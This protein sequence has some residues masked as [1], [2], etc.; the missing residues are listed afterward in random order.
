MEEARTSADNHSWDEAIE[1]YSKVLEQDID[2]DEACRQLARL[3]AVRGKFKSVI[4]SNLRLMRVFINRQD[5][6]NAVQV[7]N[8]LLLLVPESIEVRQELIKMYRSLGDM[9]EVIAR[10][11]ELARLYAE[12]DESDKALEL[13]QS[14]LRDDPQNVEVGREVAEMYIQSGQVEQGASRYRQV[15]DLYEAQGEYDKAIDAIQRV[16][17]VNNNDSNSIFHLGELF[18]KLERWDEAERQFRNTLKFNFENTEVMF[19]LGDVCQRK[20]DLDQAALAY[21][22]I[23]AMTPDFV[24]AQE[25]LGEVYQ[26]QGNGEQ[27]IKSYLSAANL[28]L[29]AHQP[30]KAISLYQRV[31]YFDNNNPTATRELT[32]LGAPVT[33]DDGGLQPVAKGKGGKGKKGKKGKGAEGGA[34][35]GLISKGGSARAGLMTKGGA[36]PGL[37]GKPVLGGDE[38]GPGSPRPGL[39]KAGLKSLGGGKMS[40]G[41]KPALG[42]KKTLSRKKKKEVEEAAAPPVEEVVEE[43]LPEVEA[44][45][46]SLHKEEEEAPLAEASAEPAEPIVEEVLPEA[47]G[48]EPELEVEPQ[49]YTPEVVPEP[50]S[51]EVEL[52]PVEDEGEYLGAEAHFNEPEGYLEEGAPYRADEAEGAAS[53]EQPYEEVEPLPGEVTEYVPA[54]EETLYGGYDFQS[55]EG[56]YAS[57][58]LPP[59]PQPYEEE[60]TGGYEEAQNW[61]DE[62]NPEL[63]NTV[64]VSQP[65]GEFS[66]QPSSAPSDYSEEY[67]QYGEEAKFPVEEIYPEA[68]YQAYD[69]E[70][71]QMETYAEEQGGGEGEFHQFAEPSEESGAQ[72]YEA[73]PAQAEESEFV[74]SYQPA[75]EVEV[76]AEESPSVVEPA[77][78]ENVEQA[79]GGEYANWEEHSTEEYHAPQ[80]EEAAPAESVEEAQPLDVSAEEEAREAEEAPSAPSAMD[81]RGVSA[82]GMRRKGRERAERKAETAPSRSKLLGND[83]LSERMARMRAEGGAETETSSEETGDHHRLSGRAAR[84]DKKTRAIMGG[85]SRSLEQVREDA[86]GVVSSEAAPEPPRPALRS[87]NKSRTSALQERIKRARRASKQAKEHASE[88]AAAVEEPVQPTSVGETEAAVVEPEVEPVVHQEPQYAEVGESVAEPAA[89]AQP[90]EGE[91]QY[92]GAYHEE[93]QSLEGEAQ[94]EG[95]YHEEVQPLEGEAQYEGAYHEEVQP[96]EG[97]AQYEG[98][99][100]EEVQPLE[101][102]AQYEGVYHE[103]VQPLEGE[104]QYE[105]AYHEEVQPLEGE[106]QYEGAYHEEVQPLE[107][108]AQYEG[109]YHEE[110]QP[111]EGEAQYEGVYHE[112][113][114]PLEGEAQYEGAYHEEVQPL[115]GEA[116]YE[117]A[118]HEEVQPLEGEAQ[119]EGA[120]HEEVQPLEGE[121]QYAG[122]YHEEIQPLEGEA[123]YEGAYHEE[124]QPLEGEAQYEGAYH[125]EVQPL[126]GEL[127]Y[128]EPA[129]EE[130]AATAAVAAQEEGYYA[131]VPL[132][133]AERLT[134]EAQEEWAT[135][136][137]IIPQEEELLGGYEAEDWQGPAPEESEETTYSGPAVEEVLAEQVVE[138]EEEEVVPPPAEPEPEL[139]EA[140]V[141]EE[142]PAASESVAEDVPPAEETAVEVVEEETASIPEEPAEPESEAVEAQTP[143]AEVVTEES[144]VTPEEGAALE[145]APVEEERVEA[146]SEPAAVETA[147][148][149]EVVAE[150]Q[151]EEVPAE[152]EVPAS[153]EVTEEVAEQVEPAP[154]EPGDGLCSLAIESELPSSYLE[155]AQVLRERLAGADVTT[156]IGDYRRAVENSPENLVLRT[157]LADIHLH[158][159]LFDD[160]INQY[161]QIIR[162][163]P[164][165]VALRHRLANAYLWSEDFEEAAKVYLELVELHNKNEQYADAVDVLQ[166]VLSLDPQNFKARGLLIERFIAE[167]KMDLAIHHLRQFVETSLSLGSVEY[168]ISAL[169]QLIAISDDPAFMERLAKVYEEHN[170]AVEALVYYRQL[171]DRYYGEKKWAEALATCEKLVSLEPQN[172]EKRHMLIE[173]YQNLGRYDQVISSQ[174]ALALLYK[175]ENMI[176]EAAKLLEE[177]I[178]RDPT[179][180]EARRRLVDCYLAQKNL[181]AAMV[182]VEPLTERYQSERLAAA[183]IDMYT[184]LVAADPESVELREKLLSFYTMDDQRDNMLK[185]LLALAEIHEKRSEYRDSVRFLRR[186]IELAPER[187]DLHCRLAK[188]YDEQLHS[189]S[190]AMQ[191]YK[192]I[193]ELAPGDAHTMRRYA[194][195]LVDQRKAKEAATVL[196]KLQSIDKAAGKEVTEEI[197]SSFMERISQDSSDLSL[198]YIYG[199]LCYYLNRISDAIEQFQKTHADRD[200]ELR[201]RNMLG[202]S[203]IKMPRMRE[204][205]IRQFRLGLDT[206]GHPEQDYLELRYNLAMLFYQTDR[207]QEALTE[208]KSILAFDVTYRDVEA[209]VKELQAKIASGGPG[210]GRSLPSRRK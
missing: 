17:V 205:A 66:F 202:L 82:T 29:R 134:G 142:L 119:Y 209:R 72:G 11:T 117:G 62:V 183:A 147:E 84:K 83:G 101:G 135:A 190:G 105:G 169:K 57:E 175:D 93:V 110:V 46:L 127:Q 43:V 197:C 180:Y 30:E 160:A 75:E 112:E 90:L 185:E 10:S 200:L 164:D 114:Q 196:L 201:S 178:K 3:Y 149:P 79:W 65:S 2:N 70:G 32:N 19:A 63:H 97:G 116:Q 88:V 89:E 8:Q 6:E 152:A 145:P 4:E 68:D 26:L 128:A 115:E 51:E 173:L 155:E 163:K 182:Q 186:A 177:I 189:M 146:E 207:L 50:Y 158:F 78:E 49:E 157:D 162:R 108:E 113:V 14:V 74:G 167:G 106:A 168:A 172:F 159:G 96:L 41:G 102:G 170:N 126:E 7:A 198:R 129:P 133:E 141:E 21:R 71:Y 55:G 67:G 45:P 206:K 98:A 208:F 80:E 121:A 5:I 107:G 195:L 194:Q 37:G 73:L 99:Y 130:M 151:A 35:S 36:K 154:E 199:E 15:A 137:Q 144:S 161:R 191:V 166:T 54:S 31:L 204:M 104:A 16:L 188:L 136:E 184:Q 210:K 40:L 187:V 59:D 156:S 24:Q 9:P 203:F 60:W 25:K 77:L 193:F 61:A 42:G 58:T 38:E 64:A 174:F 12:L 123:Q 148:T 171:L 150:V 176:D 48:I 86:A 140:E 20:G 95:A 92:E 47:Q 100:H 179:H 87:A 131:E 153:E 34:R 39:M 118:Y 44:P 165:S 53:V 94:Y 181:A 28:Y 91:A 125:E 143:A 1:L 132:S 139:V 33:P 23:V 18:V 103:E 81:L 111:L 76:P 22:K 138:P 192:K 120:Y 85:I 52:P 13:L 124:V 69:V 27:A 109:A 122:A 56:G